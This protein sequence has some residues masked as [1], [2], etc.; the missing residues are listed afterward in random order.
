MGK[1][2]P[3]SRRLGLAH[4][5]DE[6]WERLAAAKGPGNRGTQ[7][8]IALEISTL[9]LRWQNQPESFPRLKAASTDVS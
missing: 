2:L 3:G 6:A 4:A 7:A 5:L 9:T 8:R 1:L